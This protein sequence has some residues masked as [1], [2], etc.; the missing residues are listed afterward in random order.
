MVNISFWKWDNVLSPQFC[1]TALDSVNWENTEEGSVLYEGDFIVD[2]KYRAT[3][4]VWQNYMQPLGCIATTYMGAANSAA[5]WNYD[6]NWQ[7]NTQI[8]RYKSEN[9]GHYDWHQDTFMPENGV[10]RK[11]TCVILLNDPS[12][13]E[14]GELQLK[15]D[16]GSNLLTS[17][18][19]IIVFP[20]FIE[21]KVAPV[22]KGVRYTAV[23]W[24]HGPAFR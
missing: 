19:S 1:K 13:F 21:H 5:G 11:L 16:G 14:G 15:V 3:D 12:E 6:I 20:S 23:T 22:I 9:T 8:G 24:A 17:V 2:E 7:E 4:V 18:G 10:Q